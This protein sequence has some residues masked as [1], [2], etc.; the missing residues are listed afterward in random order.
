MKIAISCEGKEL[1]GKIDT[2]FGRAAGFIIY[3]TESGKAAYID[4]RQNLD[5]AQGAGIQ[6]AKKVIDAGAEALITGNVGPKAYSALSSADI[7]IY[8]SGEGNIN[9][10]ITAF[11][12]GR[13]KPAESANVEGHW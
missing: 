6:S 4:N 5:S 13:L 3:D 2:R 7:K 10:A 1:S 11:E 9:D 8:L 12:N